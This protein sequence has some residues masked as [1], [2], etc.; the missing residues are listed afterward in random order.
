MSHMSSM[1]LSIISIRCRLCRLSY[2]WYDGLAS[3]GF[4]N[5]HPYHMMMRASLHWSLIL[6]WHHNQLSILVGTIWI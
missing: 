1:F 5:F 3:L 2:P 4:P 6:K